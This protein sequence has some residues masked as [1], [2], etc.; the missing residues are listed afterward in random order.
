MTIQAGR[1]HCPNYVYSHQVPHTSV[2]D[3][4]DLL[5]ADGARSGPT[6]CSD[7]EAGQRARDARPTF[8]ADGPVWS[9][10]RPRLI[11][12][13]RL[14]GTTEERP[15]SLR[16]SCLSNGRK[17]S[18]PTGD[19]YR[20]VLMWKSPVEFAEGNEGDICGYPKVAQARRGA[21]WQGL[22]NRT[23]PTRRG[24]TTPMQSTRDV[25]EVEIEDHLLLVPSG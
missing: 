21:A 22:S 18:A 7:L 4:R 2:C 1:G 5:G 16:R 25:I 23:T 8:T 13:L 17:Q 24:R 11:G 10:A 12:W 19:N 3:V 20:D 14:G 9:G 6:P 15:A